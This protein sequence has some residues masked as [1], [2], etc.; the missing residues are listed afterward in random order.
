MDD[1]EEKK[2]IRQKFDDS[3][4]RNIKDQSKRDLGS[5][6]KKGPL[7]KNLD[8]KSIIILVQKMKKILRMILIQKVKNLKIVLAVPRLKILLKRI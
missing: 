4:N 7:E 6:I 2:N 1:P 8:Q 5:K 3:L